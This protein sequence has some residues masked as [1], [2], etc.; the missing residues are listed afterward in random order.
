MGMTSISQADQ[1]TSSD[2]AAWA[3][4]GGFLLTSLLAV[5]MQAWQGCLDKLE[6]A[7]ALG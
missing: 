3:L 2:G 6:L 7:S 4:R 1:M 5:R